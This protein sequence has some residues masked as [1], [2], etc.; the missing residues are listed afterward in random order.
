MLL[1]PHLPYRA[2]PVQE[3]VPRLHSHAILM[4]L[5]LLPILVAKLH[6]PSS[7]SPVDLLMVSFNLLQVDNQ[8]SAYPGLDVFIRPQ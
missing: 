7:E 4:S 6:K 1:G 3:A 2:M 5:L 8:A